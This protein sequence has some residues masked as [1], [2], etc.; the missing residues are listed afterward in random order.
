VPVPEQRYAKNGDVNALHERLQR[1]LAALPG[2]TSVGATTA[3]PFDGATNQTDVEFPGAPGNTGD[4]D[5]DSPLV[6]AVHVLPGYFETLQ[7]RVLAGRTFGA[8]APAGVHEAVIDRTLASR[9]FPRGSAVGA[10]MEFRGDSLVVV[11][12]VEHARQYDVHQDGRP[13]VYVRNADYPE[14]TISFALRSGRSPAALVSDVRAAVGRVDAQLALAEVRPMEEYVHEA[15]RQPRLSAVLLSAFSVGA[16]L[17]AAMGLYGV[18][19]GAVSRRRH[20]LAVR[21]ALGAN[22]SG[23]LRLVLREGVGLIAV[24]LLIGVPGVLLAGRL[25]RGV[26]V[27]V[28]PVDPPTLAAVAALLA[29]VAL[30]ACY[31]P[32]RRVVE[33]E[34]ARLLRQG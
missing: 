18:I 5:Q 12:V 13:Q 20:E 6:D 7:I 26:L 24:G 3:L 33:I 11:G 9:F 21:L 15:L 4:G 31:L 34:P 30:V 27:G 28:S 29:L 25:I 19:A 10:R 32:A 23:V 22:H 8:A 2:V 16:L 1:E 14:A 17:L